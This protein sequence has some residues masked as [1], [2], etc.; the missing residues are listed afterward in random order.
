MKNGQY[1][2]EHEEKLSTF[3]TKSPL[4]AGFFM[5]AEQYL[6]AILLTY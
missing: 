2:A 1:V 3:E 4:S 5:P 6:L